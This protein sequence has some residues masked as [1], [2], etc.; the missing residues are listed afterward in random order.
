MIE[1][2]LWRVIIL[3]VCSLS[4]QRYKENVLRVLVL[5]AMYPTPERPAFG[6]FVQEQVDSLRKAGIDVEV[7]CFTGGHSFRNYIRAGIALRKRLRSERFDLIHAHYGLVALPALMQLSCP[8]VVTYHGSDLI[9][10]IGPKGGYTFAGRLKVILCK[11]LGY[12]VT[13]RIIVAELLRTKLWPSTLIP[14]GVDMEL[15]RPR[16]RD[17]VR[18]QLDL[19]PMRKYIVFVA[20][21]GNRRKRFDL[22]KAAVELVAADHPDVELLPVFKAT[23][24]QVPLYMNASNVLILTSDHEASPCVIKEALASNLPIVTVDC[25]DVVERIAGVDGAFLCERDP[26]DIAAKLRAAL[27]F[28]GPTNGREMVAA[29]SLEATARQTIAVFES[30]MRQRNG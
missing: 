11:A 8:V 17:Q 2:T 23:H 6:T 30:A 28:D 29:I 14:M 24:D 22:A 13:Q 18:K 1:T 25:G 15:F 26:N 27:A 10:E 5:T 12:R 16:P 3:A 20:N 4:P 21:P 9:G 19:D 7:M